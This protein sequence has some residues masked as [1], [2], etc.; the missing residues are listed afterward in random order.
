M[1][2]LT[3]SA[4]VDTLMQAA[5][6]AAFKTSLSLNNVENTALSTWAGTT[7]VTTLGTV[8]T[9]TWQGTIVGSTY[10]G[11]GNAFFAVS[12]PASTTKTYTFPN[13]SCTILT[14]NAAVTVA[15]GGTGAATLSGIIYGNGTVALTAITSSTAGQVL[16]VTGANTF[17]FGAV[18][19]A[20]ADAI[21]G[22]LPVGN[23]NSGTSAS[24]T[25]FWR[26]D[27][28]WATPSGGGDVTAAANF[29]NDNRVIRSDG[30]LKGVQASAVTIDDSGNMTGIGDMTGTSLAVD[31]LGINDTDDSH[32]MQV[33]CG[34]NL[35]ANRILTFT[36]GDAA[37]TVTIQGD[38]TLPAGTAVVTSSF[39]TGVAT[40][41]GLAA[42]GTD[43]DAIGFRGVP[44]N[45]QTGNYTC[46]MAD[47]GKHVIHP[48]GG[49]AGDTITIP[50]NG[51]VA[52]EVGTCITFVNGDS[53]SCS[54]A[55]TTDTMTLAGTTTTGTRTLAQNGIATA[56]KIASTSWIINGTG[57][58]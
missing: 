26:G 11:T 51:S 34:S 25:T 35:T 32:Q 5:N 29:T 49:G 7:N 54:I 18:D 50:A 30:T 37:R 19:L 58:T 57:L 36:P 8:A 3:V 40:Q 16:R 39:G 47:A 4:N 21:T 55:I 6:F 46:V 15:Q 24:A 27:G 9:G 1:P 43:V 13:A 23:L 2:D 17:A 53:N 56:I 45:S 10:G 44:Q 42:D 33:A 31:T 20:D 41:L 28:T 38:V 48:S 12:G 22:N 14:T 52:Y